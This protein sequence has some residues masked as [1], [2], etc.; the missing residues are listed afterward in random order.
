M[1]LCKAYFMSHLNYCVQAQDQS[2]VK[3]TEV[4]ERIQVYLTRLLWNWGGSKSCGQQFSKL[5]PFTAE[6]RRARGD[7]IKPHK[8]PKNVSG[9]LLK[10]AQ[11]ATLTRANHFVRRTTSSWNVPSQDIVSSDIMIM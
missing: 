2:E 8:I 9:V 1:P 10:T 3:Y 7:F 4:L 5:G 6:Q 11:V